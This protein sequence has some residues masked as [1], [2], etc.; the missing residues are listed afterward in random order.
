MKN[1]LQNRLIQSYVPLLHQYSFL[2][3]NQVN[4]RVVIGQSAVDY[5]VGKPAEKSRVFWIIK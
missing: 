3:N 1:S 4:V 2:Y 5:C